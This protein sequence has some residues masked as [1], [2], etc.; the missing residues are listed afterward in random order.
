[1]SQAAYP[2]KTMSAYRQVQLGKIP[3]GPHGHTVRY[4]LV[5]KPG[6][7]LTQDLRTTR[8]GNVD[9]RTLGDTAPSLRAVG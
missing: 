6:E 2:G 5:E 9:V 4:Q 7:Q 3:I 1:M 8:Q